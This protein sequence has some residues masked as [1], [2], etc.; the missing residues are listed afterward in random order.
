MS[1]Y[2]MLSLALEVCPMTHYYSF[3]YLLMMPRTTTDVSA[4]AKAGGR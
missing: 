1:Y 2:F 3:N 4:Q